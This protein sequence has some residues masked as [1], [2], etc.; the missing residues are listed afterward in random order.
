MKRSYFIITFF[1][2]LLMFNGC[3]KEDAQRDVEQSLTKSKEDIISLYQTTSKYGLARFNKKYGNLT[4]DF[5]AIKV[6]K[7]DNQKIVSL[8]L[9]MD[10]VTNVTLQLV[11]INQ[12]GKRYAQI[13]EFIANPDKNSHKNKTKDGFDGRLNIYLVNGHFYRKYAVN[14]GEAV[15]ITDEAVKRAGTRASSNP[16]DD[17]DGDGV[18]NKDDKCPNTPPQ[19]WVDPEGCP[20]DN[21]LP[22]VDIPSPGN[23]GTP[24]DGGYNPNPGSPG[25]TG[26]PGD[27][28]GDDSGGS[29]GNGG[30]GGNSGGS[31]ALDNQVED[32]C[33]SGVV[34]E[35]LASNISF[36]ANETLQSIFGWNGHFNIKYMEGS[37]MPN[38]VDGSAQATR[39][40]YD[41]DG[42]IT[43][44]DITVLFN[45]NNLSNASR[46]YIALVVVHESIHA[47][48]N[49]QGYAYS[50]N[51]HDVMLSQ[52]L[53]V[54]ALH[55]IDNYNTPLQDAYSLAMAGLQ[56]AFK[57]SINNE[58]WETL[59]EKYKNKLPNLDERSRIEADYQYGYK[60][61]KCN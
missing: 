53:D 6:T 41:N 33:V 27:G 39:I 45:I 51:Q 22:P 31:S 56:E 8:P 26:N 60:G 14:D 40:L 5:N 4:A 57:N 16:N 59:E 2:A 23:P 34:D 9:K 18:P 42:K 58:T 55:L 30:G 10:F 3:T 25:D 21:E 50:T 19:T 61:S 49:Y 54:M 46:E 43:D 12:D 24:G 48:L 36:K 11:I 47:Y 28:P 44:M 13:T 15:F 32:P 1:I 29:G 52:Y 17:D 37:N 35:V 20:V 38:G 7:K